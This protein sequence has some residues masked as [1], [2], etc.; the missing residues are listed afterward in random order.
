MR[1]FLHFLIII[2]AV[3]FIVLWLMENPGE[4]SLTWFG[5]KLETSVAVL[6]GFFVLL[7][8]VVSV[9]KAPLSL[10]KWMRH[11]K[12]TKQI[13]FREKLIFQ[14]LN[15]YLAKDA[16]LQKNTFKKIDKT[17]GEGNVYSLILK[18]MTCP[19]QEVAL[20]LASIDETH[21]AGIKG[22]ITAK[23]EQGDFKGALDI[24]I[25]AKETKPSVWLNADIFRLQIKLSRW[26]EALKTLDDLKSARAL[27]KE[28]YL[29]K[30]ASILLKL[31]R[32]EEA[33]KTAPFI[34][35]TA[36]R[37]AQ[38]VPQKATSILKKAWKKSP[39]WAL[40]KAFTKTLN[41]EKPLSAY[42]TAEKFIL[43]A[44]TNPLTH[45]ALADAALMAHL[46]GQAGKEL[47]LYLD[48]YPLTVPAAEMKIFLEKE[49]NNN[50]EAVRIWEDKLQ[51]LGPYLP[52]TCTSC[53]YATS[54]WDA[55]C[56]VCQT[57]GK[58]K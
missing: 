35:E 2:L 14:A 58:I 54:S 38:Q 11:H 30:K 27:T 50:S 42:K 9:L 4:V 56:P 13:A 5:Y 1:K 49:A 29:S 39:N 44:D 3:I 52:Y 23:E 37:Y 19:T 17:F 21:M 26:D 16:V 51:K 20:E 10:I 36:L 41:P 40:Y 34:P 12:E 31:G 53:G 45:L 8:M 32:N 18:Q 15:A 43:S 57:F 28:D 6:I 22:L 47:D 46:W 7:S 33:F 55:S 25:N 24:A 48:A